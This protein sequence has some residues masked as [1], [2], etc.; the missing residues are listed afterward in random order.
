MIT[1][2]AV[3]PLTYCPLS[4]PPDTFNFS[5]KSSTVS[6]PDHDSPSLV[7][8]KTLGLSAQSIQQLQQRLKSNDDSLFHAGRL[9]NGKTYVVTQNDKLYY[10]WPNALREIPVPHA[11]RTRCIDKQTRDYTAANGLRI[12]VQAKN[13]Q[14]KAQASLRLF[15][16]SLPLPHF[17]QIG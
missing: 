10:G 15:G 6:K 9:L 3:N 7:P 14:H 5:A 11:T 4:Q 8:L 1:G 17:R 16:L 2:R 12:R 13:A